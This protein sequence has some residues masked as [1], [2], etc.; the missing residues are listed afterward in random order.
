MGGASEPRL[1]RAAAEGVGEDAVGAGTAV[2]E[3]GDATTFPVRDSFAGP[4]S[5]RTRAAH[6][7]TSTLITNTAGPWAAFDM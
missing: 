6:A 7:I 3:G 5:T 4:A 2:V 1:P